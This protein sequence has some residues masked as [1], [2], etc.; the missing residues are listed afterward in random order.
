MDISDILS[1][2]AVI[3][4]KT[5][6]CWENEEAQEDMI[7]TIGAMCSFVP[8]QTEPH[9]ETWLNDLWQVLEVIFLK[10]KSFVE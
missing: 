1:Q 5:I 6:L 7:D 10:L 2:I 9:W 4:S 8:K 3:A